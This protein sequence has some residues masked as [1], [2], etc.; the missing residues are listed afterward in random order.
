MHE[1][2]QTSRLPAALRQAAFSA[3][4]RRRDVCRVSCRSRASC[5]CSRRLWWGVECDALE[6]GAHESECVIERRGPNKDA[7]WNA[8]ARD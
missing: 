4:Q 1:S 7:F 2:G 8:Q 6:A 3:M 5:R